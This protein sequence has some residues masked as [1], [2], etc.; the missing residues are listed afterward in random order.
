METSP[1]DAKIAA[2]TERLGEQHF[3]YTLVFG[4]GPVQEADKIPSTGRE[5]LNFYSRMISLAAAEMLKKGIT[6]HVIVSG[7]QTGARAGTPEGRTEAEL[8]ADSIRRHLTRGSKD[9]DVFIANGQK[10]RV[11]DAVLI[12]NQ[13][14]DSLQNLAFILKKYL[15]EGRSD[16]Q[17]AFLGIG[18]HAHDTLSGANEGRLEV[19]ADLFGINAPV[20]AA[21]GVLRELTISGR[22]EEGFVRKQL[23]RLTDITLT[24]PVSILKSQQEAVLVRGLR[25]GDWKRIA[26]FLEHPQ[27]LR[28]VLADSYVSQ[29]LQTELSLDPDQIRAM[30]PSALLDALKNLKVE[31]S[32]GYGE[33]KAAVLGA[34]DAMENTT[35]IPYL[36]MYG[37]ATV[38]Y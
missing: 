26:P 18:F 2:K 3:T 22:S 36:Q 8:M 16:K 32:K 5:G 31:G 34:L 11:S 21:E 35:G 15:P 17:L 27:I 13:A 33:I 9:P 6:D 7:G 14:K 20:Y 10:K 28:M 4:Q 19:L 37:K 30:A 25:A 38:N 1:L 12:E 24:D 29:Q 23:Q